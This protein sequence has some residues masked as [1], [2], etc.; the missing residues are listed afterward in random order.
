MYDVYSWSTSNGRKV[1]IML[2]EL[3]VDYTI[4]PIEIGRGDQF[5]PE[6][7]TINP[8]QKIPAIVDN[9]GPSGKAFK[10]FESGAILLYLGEKH[11]QFYPKEITKRYEVLQWLMFKMGGVGPMF[12]QAHNFRR[13][14]GEKVPY[15]IERYTK[16]TRRLWSVLDTRL[17]DRN[18]IAADEYSIADIAIFPW[19]A[20]FEWQGISLDEF[21]NVKRWYQTLEA[22]PAV[23]TGMVPMQP[24]GK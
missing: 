22:R 2:E 15:A 21:P 9:D 14:S 18:W 16:E 12:G 6:F 23:Q 24:R 7:T 20:R 8:N 1:H 13:S 11:G 3:G 19:C 17:A 5:T 10:V 4:H